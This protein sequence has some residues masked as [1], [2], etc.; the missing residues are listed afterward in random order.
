MHAITLVLVIVSLT[1][2]LWLGCWS[3]NKPDA[4][5]HAGAD[6]QEVHPDFAHLCTVHHAASSS[7]I[8]QDAKS[9]CRST[10]ALTA[11]R[12]TCRGE[13]RILLAP[14]HVLESQV[15]TD[16]WGDVKLQRHPIVQVLGITCCC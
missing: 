3:N 2:D 13:L 11:E 4:V 10:M 9:S 8:M 7:F 1:E 12:L 6:H 5:S 16:R 15:T 14:K